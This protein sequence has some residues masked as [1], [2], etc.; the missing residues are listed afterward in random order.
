MGCVFY[1]SK[2]FFILSDIFILPFV[3]YTEGQKTVHSLRPLN[4]KLRYNIK[5]KFIMKN[6]TAKIASIALASILS[7]SSM[8][9]LTAQVSAETTSETLV[10]S[11]Y[12]NSKTGWQKVGRKIY[13]YGSDGVMYTG[14]QKIGSKTYLFGS[15]GA[16]KTG[17]QTIGGNTFYFGR[18]GVMRTGKRKI[19]G[20][21]YRFDKYGV[22]NGS[23]NYDP[24]SSNAAADVLYSMK[25]YL[26]SSYTCDNVHDSDDLKNYGFDMR[27]VNSCV[28]EDDS[29]SAINY[30]L[31]IVVNVKDG[32]ADKAVQIL[33]DYYQQILSVSKLYDADVYR[34]E[35]ARIFSQDNYVA[36]LILGDNNYSDSWSDDD[37]SDYAFAEAL[38]V[39][40]AWKS[41]FGSTPENLA[42]IDE[43]DGIGS[44]APSEVS[45][46][47]K[48]NK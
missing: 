22:L 38:K 30:D 32:Y 17:W 5:E 48:T 27:Y 9:S 41:I 24:K 31:A 1:A 21:I 39:D 47:V 45:S 14:W 12:D 35:Q 4:I 26:G 23:G 16:M 19:N 11:Y 7:V 10:G 33:Q 28:Y 6:I 3:I 13:Y 40:K 34:V 8:A 29:I 37:K 25:S 18:N 43:D 44:A 15:D 2:N 36:L 42:E 20:Q 46:N